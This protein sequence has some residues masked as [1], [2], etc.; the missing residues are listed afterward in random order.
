MT[1]NEN[2]NNFNMQIEQRY[3]ISL[4][5]MVKSDEYN[6][7]NYQNNNSIIEDTYKII[8]HD[9]IWNV[10][11]FMLGFILFPIWLFSCFYIKNENSTVRIIANVN[12]SF[13]IFFLCIIIY[14][15]YFYYI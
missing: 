7:E 8:E 3:D 12:I 6:L 11:F 15:F 5:N 13:F 9:I 14:I 10:L 2:F 4:N 1:Y